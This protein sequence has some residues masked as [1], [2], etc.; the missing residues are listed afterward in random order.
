MTTDAGN[1][2]DTSTAL[3]SGGPAAADGGNLPFDDKSKEFI[4]YRQPKTTHFFPD[5]IEK[6]LQNHRKNSSPTIKKTDSK[7]V[8]VKTTETKPYLP[9]ENE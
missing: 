5:T 3:H 7:F 6:H 4:E 9:S 8:I 1:T 2:A